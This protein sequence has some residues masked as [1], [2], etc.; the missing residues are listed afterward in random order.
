M[1]LTLIRHT[2]VDVPK[3]ICYGITDVPLALTFRSELE[4]IR[5]KLADKIFDAVFSSPLSRC[6]KLATELFPEEQLRIDHR[7]TELDFGDWEMMPWDE[8]FESPEGKVW[9]GNYTRAC[10]PNGESLIDLISRTKMF[11]DDLKEMKHERIVLLTHAGVIRAL[12][13]LIQHKTPEEAFQTPL[14]YGQIL[15]FNLQR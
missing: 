11:L 5:Q 3:G 15:S 14:V 2:S 12:M 6:T 13:C 9:F 8:I 4:S 7:L 1:K 10:C